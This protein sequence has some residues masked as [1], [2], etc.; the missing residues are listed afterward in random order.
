VEGVKLSL[1]GGVVRVQAQDFAP[2]H[3]GLSRTPRSGQTLPES[4]SGFDGLGFLSHGQVEVMDSFG[5]TVHAQA[6]RPQRISG[7]V[8]FRIKAETS[9]V[10]RECL[11]EAAKPVKDSGELETGVHGLG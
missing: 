8:M 2:L 11:G 1:G 10:E 5:Q 9:G 3:L 7:L 6:E 4:Q